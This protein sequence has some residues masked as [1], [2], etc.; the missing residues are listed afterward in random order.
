M[1]LRVIEK[2]VVARCAD[3]MLA[4]L[5]EKAK[6]TFWDVGG[7]DHYK[8]AKLLAGLDG[9][10]HAT[11]AE[12]DIRAARERLKVLDKREALGL[13]SFRMPD[14]FICPITLQ[15]MKGA[16]RRPRMRM[17]VSDVHRAVI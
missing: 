11:V 8:A 16:R 14:E 5:G 10:A 3:L 17:H 9:N 2:L 6:E 15:V 1:P 7:N 4:R 13:G 12:S